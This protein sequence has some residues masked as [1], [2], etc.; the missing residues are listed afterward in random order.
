M[1][2]RQ[3]PACQA[4]VAANETDCPRC[5]VPGPSSSDAAG[6]KKRWPAWAWVLIGVG[7]GCPAVIV[8]LGLLATLIVPNMLEK[9]DATGGG[10][11]KV[12]VDITTLVNGLNEYAI[13]N[14]GQYPDSLEAL[15]VPDENGYRYLQLQRIPRDPWKG[16]YHY[17][18]PPAD[19][20][21]LGPH[22]WSNGMDGV[23]GGDDDIDSRTM[24]D[25]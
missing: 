3:C 17:E 10:W 24:N 25:D 18:P 8:V 9:F 19:A 1:Q 22:V 23:P 21:E 16:E 20:P 7:C 12:R 6:A 11:H 13:R 5:G 4:D 2:S 14:A 15:V